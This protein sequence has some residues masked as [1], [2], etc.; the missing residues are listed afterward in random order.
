MGR[1]V[2]GAIT[3]YVAANTIDYLTAPCSNP[4][5]PRLELRNELLF[6]GIRRSLTENGAELLWI[7]TGHLHIVEDSV[8]SQRT[9]LWASEWVGD[10]IV[11]RAYAD[12]K[13]QAYQ[14][15]GRAEAQAEMVLSIMDTLNDVAISTASPVEVRKLLL[16]RTAQLLDSMS[17]IPKPEKDEK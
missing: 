4:A 12:A 6:R 5:N 16:L 2:V 10:S 13:R 15:L 14:E 1:I 7:D 3:D 9:D 8:D 17:S 11:T